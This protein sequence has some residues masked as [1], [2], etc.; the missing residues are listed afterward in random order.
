[1]VYQIHEMISD[2]S[3]MV[4]HVNMSINSSA[5]QLVRNGL[6]QSFNIHDFIYL[7]RILMK[8]L[9]NKR[10]NLFNYGIN[11]PQVRAINNMR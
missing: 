3:F 7:P 6:F 11:P 9:Y 5:H 1:M 10:L 4:I 8:I 2:F